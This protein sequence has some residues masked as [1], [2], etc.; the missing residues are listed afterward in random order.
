MSSAAFNS[1]QEQAAAALKSTTTSRTS[2]LSLPNEI[3]DRI[4][5]TVLLELIE[6]EGTYAELVSGH[7]P[8]RPCAPH[9]HYYDLQSRALTK[10]PGFT[11]SNI[12]AKSKHKPLPTLLIMVDY[13]TS[14]SSRL[15]T[16][17]KRLEGVLKTGNRTFQ[18]ILNTPSWELDCYRIP[19]AVPILRSLHGREAL[20]RI[21]EMHYVKFVIITRH[22]DGLPSFQTIQ[23]EM[24][25]FLKDWTEGR[26]LVNEPK[27]TLLWKNVEFEIR[28]QEKWFK[29][30]FLLERGK[31]W[32]LVYTA[33]SGRT[34]NRTK[35]I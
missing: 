35:R 2:I 18:V 29:F 34:L 21:K 16:A 30:R 8:K 13:I 26:V 6:N 3:R 1:S 32:T 24:E 10:V 15:W 23:E 12:W 17:P 4:C 11:A 27:H 5:E 25:E 22:I 7:D 20:G 9:R 33:E 19:V 31:D 14:L 28:G